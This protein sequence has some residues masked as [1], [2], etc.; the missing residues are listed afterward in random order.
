MEVL[1]SFVLDSL[2]PLP[3]W[4]QLLPHEL[5]QLIL[6]T[7]LQLLSFPDLDAALSM[8]SHGYNHPPPENVA[9]LQG[10]DNCVT[11]GESC[12]R[13]GSC[14]LTRFPAVSTK[15]S[16]TRLHA[17][18]IFS[19]SLRMDD[20]SIHVTVGNS[21]L[22]PLM[23][24]FRPKTA[25]TNKHWLTDKKSRPQLLT[26]NHYTEARVYIFQNGKGSPSGAFLF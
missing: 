11:A 7:C 8:W 25:E 19:V 2:L 6:P 3:I 20:N 26:P 15:D 23:P 21:V 10:K 16:G 17:L 4:P 13:H 24:M 18:P 1:G 14:S 22:P 5:M 12:R 9:Y